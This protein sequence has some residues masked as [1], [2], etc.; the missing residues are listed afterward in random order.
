[1]VINKEGDQDSLHR[2]VDLESKICKYIRYTL[3]LMIGKIVVEFLT[4]NL[5]SLVKI[6]LESARDRLVNEITDRVELEASSREEIF[7][8]IHTLTK[9]S[10]EKFAPDVEKLRSSIISEFRQRFFRIFSRLEKA[11]QR[12]E[13]P[14]IGLDLYFDSKYTKLRF[15]KSLSDI[16]AR[17]KQTNQL[18]QA[19][20]FRFLY[21]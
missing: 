5:F 19:G 14:R 20:R 4:I 7:T 11:R 10:V 9:K 2:Q 18:D 6:E 3:Q 17:K 12:F 1:M 16:P 15:I 8:R 21:F 13:E